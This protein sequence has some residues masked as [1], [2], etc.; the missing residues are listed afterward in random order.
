VHFQFIGHPLAGDETYGQRQTKRLAELTHYEP[1]RVMLH[2]QQLAFVHPRSG[3]RLRFE[4]PWPADFSD[5]VKFL[6]PD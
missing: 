5:A 6:K 1:P 3:K 4:A 2:A